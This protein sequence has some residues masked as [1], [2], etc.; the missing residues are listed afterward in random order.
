MEA[1]LLEQLAADSGVLEWPVVVP[2]ES[3]HV[4]TILRSLGIPALVVAHQGHP[5]LVSGP[6]TTSFESWKLHCAAT[7]VLAAAP[8]PILNQRYM[9]AA[10]AAAA[11]ATAATAATAAAAATAATAA[12][13]LGPIPLDEWSRRTRMFESAAII[14]L[15]LP[16]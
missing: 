5:Y 7:N 1:Y 13:S 12:T 3:D 4:L 2:H 11:A 16:A 15:R 10:A 14:A 6:Y 9:L 8:A